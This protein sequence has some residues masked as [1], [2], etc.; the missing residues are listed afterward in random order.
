VSLCEF[1]A[2]AWAAD[3][4]A[5]LVGVVLSIVAEYIPPYNDLPAKWK[6]IIFLG[7]AVLVAFGAYFL[8]P[9]LG[10]PRPDWQAVIMVILLVFGGGTIA[11]TRK[12]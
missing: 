8:A 10:C 12:L 9:A 7:A 1:L 3:T 6:R 11:H 2:Q 4:L 5:L